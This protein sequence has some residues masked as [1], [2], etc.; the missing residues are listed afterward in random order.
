MFSFLRLRARVCF[1][2]Q[3]GGFKVFL[4]IIRIVEMHQMYKNKFQAH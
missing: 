1:N 4:T 2:M 3:W